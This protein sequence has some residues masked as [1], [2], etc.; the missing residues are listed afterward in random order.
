MTFS[1]FIIILAIIYVIYYGIN[2]L[3]DF[4]SAKSGSSLQE[5][6]NI[7][8]DLQGD[9]EPKKATLDSDELNLNEPDGGRRRNLEGHQE[10]TVNNELQAENYHNLGVDLG[11]ETISPDGLNV[12]P[13]KL[14][15][16]A[17][18]H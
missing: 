1:N 7:E 9:F 5:D 18:S 4:F 13:D 14:R 16:I 8:F 2:I 12:T 3:I 11:L 15:K 10:E 17:R 6:R